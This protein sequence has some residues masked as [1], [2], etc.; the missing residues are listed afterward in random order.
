MRTYFMET[1]RLGF[2]HW[3]EG[4]IALARQLWGEP[5]VTHYISA[6]G[7]FTEQMIADRLVLECENQRVHGVQ[8]WPI[9]ALLTGDLVGCCGLRPYAAEPGVYE[10]GVHLRGLYWGQGLA[11]EACEA[12]IRDAF[13]RL[14]AADLFAGHHP[15]NAASAALLQRLGFHPIGTEFYAPDRKSTRLNS[16]H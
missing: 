11:Q 6:T 9:F 4:D 8:Y 7:V 16:S 2:S 12:V 15:E 3:G 5:D 1:F 10:L 14:G 13:E